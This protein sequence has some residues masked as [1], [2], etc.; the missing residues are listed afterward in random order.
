MSPPE[1]LPEIASR[2][3]RHGFTE[4]ELHTPKMER[5]VSILEELGAVVVAYSGGVDSAF[6]L[7]VAR[8]VLGERAVGV[9]GVSESLDRAEMAEARRTAEVAGLPLCE[10]ET[11][12]YDNPAYRLNDGS[13]CYHCKSE[14]FGVLAAYAERIG[15]RHVVDGSNADDV[16]DYRP[17]LRA[18]GEHGV[19][20]P[21]LEAGLGKDEIRAASRALGLRT[22]DKPAAPCLSS[23][24]PYG[25]P[26]TSE[27]LRQVEAAERALRD[28]GFRV[29]RVRHHGDVARIEVPREDLPRLL[30]PGLGARLSEE[31]RAAGFLH[32][33]VDLDGFRSGGLNAALSAADRPGA[34]R[35]GGGAGSS[36]G[37]VASDG[38]LSDGGGGATG[39]TG[40]GERGPHVPLESVRRLPG[41]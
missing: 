34:R 8:G 41:R 3:V 35:A 12:E 33:A 11:H 29:V 39:A 40:R 32:V 36:G 1:P 37:V 14:L 13:R 19:R 9:L 6:L 5:L 15:V 24:I 4:P 26:V 17:G 31:V 10:V 7:R 28:A 27:R 38:A 22:W 16:G 18:R 25:T 2:L 30:E 21:L 23:R 20:S